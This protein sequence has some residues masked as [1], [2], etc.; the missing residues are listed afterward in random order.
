MKYYSQFGQDLWLDRELENPNDKYFVDVGASHR[1][2]GYMSNTLFFE[3]NYNWNGL[4]IEPN[5][6][7]HNPL[8]R[9]K[10]TLIKQAAFSENKIARFKKNPTG[11][12]SVISEKGDSDVSCETLNNILN[13][14]NAPK[15]IDF[16]S[17]D[18]DGYEIDVLLG[19]DFKEYSFDK[20]IVEHNRSTEPIV[21]ILTNAGYKLIEEFLHDLYF[22]LEDFKNK[23]SSL[24]NEWRFL[25][26]KATI[27]NDKGK[28]YLYD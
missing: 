3:E 5:D 20:I 14:N 1:S 26:N 28:H 23:P 15:F 6:K 9:R 19:I 13:K 8:K 7:L 12:N 4:L 24:K 11:A 22:C 2:N 18:T 10:S 27:I 16:L 17:V 25:T 21:K